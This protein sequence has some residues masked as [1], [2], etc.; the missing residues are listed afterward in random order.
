MRIT[1]FG[2]HSHALRDIGIRPQVRNALAGQRYLP[3]RRHRLQ[4]QGFTPL[5][6]DGKVLLVPVVRGYDLVIN[7]LAPGLDQQELIGPVDGK[8]MAEMSIG[9]EG[10][11]AVIGKVTI[12]A[13]AVQEHAFERT[14]N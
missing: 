12:L 4:F 1:I 5:C 10:D 3:D 7:G 11:R 9:L 2:A 6:V 8:P 14:V 13:A